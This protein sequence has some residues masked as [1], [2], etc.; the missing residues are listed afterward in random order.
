MVTAKVLH[1]VTSKKF[2]GQKMYFPKY[3]IQWPVSYVG[4]RMG[5]LQ[6]L[7]PFSK[8]G[9]PTYCLTAYGLNSPD[10]ICILHR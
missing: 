5:S 8:L 4:E 1:G 10:A 7:P 2:K 9:L 6:T 3:W